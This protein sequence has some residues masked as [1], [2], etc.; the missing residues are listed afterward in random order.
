MSNPSILKFWLNDLVGNFNST[1]WV[2]EIGISLRNEIF[3]SSS[4]Q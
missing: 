4:M 3:S 2:K 1:L